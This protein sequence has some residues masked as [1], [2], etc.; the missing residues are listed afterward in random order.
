VTMKPVGVGV[1]GYGHYVRGNFLP[2]F[3]ACPAIHIVGVYNRGDE[4]RRQATQDGYWTTGRLDE[5]L[6]RPELEAVYIGTANAAHK[7]QCIAAARAGKHILCD[8][9][10]ALSLQEVNEIIAE[11]RKAGVIT[12]VNHGAPYSQSFQTFQKIMR[13][14]AGRLLHVWVRTS[15]GFGNWAHGARHRAVWHPEESGGWTMHH[16]C[17]ALDEACILMSKKPVKA[18]H[19]MMKS[20]DECPS[21]EIVN[22]LVTFE[23]GSTALLSDGVTIGGFLDKGVMGVDGDMRLSGDTI[24]LVTQGPPAKRGRPGILE[25]QVE[26]FPVPPGEDKSTPIVAQAFAS[27]I[28]GGENR[29]LSFDFVRDQYRILNAL[30]KSAE[31]GSAVTIEE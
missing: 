5:L 10:L 31:T 16:L 26:T 12:H 29:L 4:R 1:L 7:E 21:E 6:A 3:A 13:E 25:R 17:H 24:T 28:R 15:R 30:K 11:T 20:T 19:T 9:P 18:Y 14:R 23:D 8:K 27:A 2:Q 22:S